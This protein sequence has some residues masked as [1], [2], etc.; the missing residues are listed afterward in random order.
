SF[1][2]SRWSTTRSGQ[3]LRSS[4]RY[5]RRSAEHATTPRVPASHAPVSA[6]TGQRSSSVSGSPRAIFA[7]FDAGWSESASRNASPS[8]SAS[9]APT[10]DL[11]DPETP[12]TTTG[13]PGELMSA[14]YPVGWLLLSLRVVDDRAVEGLGEG[15]R[16]AEVVGGVGADPGTRTERVADD[17]VPVLGVVQ[18]AADGVEHVDHL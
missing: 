14:R 9:T 12:I 8:R 6:R 17:D 3:C 10:V 5:D 7:T 18:P 1:G 11:P 16:L 2:A 4:S 13:W 15:G